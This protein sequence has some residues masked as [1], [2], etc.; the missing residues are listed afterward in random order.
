M[1]TLPVPQLVVCVGAAGAA[2]GGSTL[3]CSLCCHLT[4]MKHLMMVIIASQAAL[5]NGGHLTH[6]SK[7]KN[8]PTRIATPPP[9]AFSAYAVNVFA[10]TPSPVA[11]FA[12]S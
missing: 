10:F 1:H 3:A 8:C 5:I 11:S 9:R 7:Q 2:R 12:S 6:Q 4:S